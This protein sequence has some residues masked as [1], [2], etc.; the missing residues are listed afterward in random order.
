MIYK[1]YGSNLQSVDL[2]FDSKALNEV[3]FTRNREDVIERESFERSFVRSG[4]AIEL[5]ATAEGPVQGEVED[6]LLARLAAKVR[7]IEENLPSD[8]ILVVESE[9]GKDYPK[10][11]HTTKNIIVDGE[12]R[13]YFT[14]VLDPALRVGIYRRKG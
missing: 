9:S 3:G 11:R 8:E 14:Y 7:E 1:W 4:D 2:N 10:T 13:L 5:V 6:D 12:N